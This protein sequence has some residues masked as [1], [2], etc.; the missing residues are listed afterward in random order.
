A[1]GH[2]GQAGAGPVSAAGAMSDRAVRNL[3]IMPAL[4]LLIVFNVFPLLASLAVSFA[5]YNPIIDRKPVFNGLA[6]YAGLLDGPRQEVWRA[7]SRTGAFVAVSV[8]L[9][10]LIGF[11]VALLLRRAFKGRGLFTAILLIP[12]MLSP[13]V[14]GSFWRYLFNA[15]YGAV[16]WLLNARLNWDGSRPLAFW[17][18]VIAE[19]WMWTPFMI[20]LSLAGLN[21]I[22]KAL[23]EAAEVDRAGAWFRFR[24]ITL[25]L[26][27]PM[28]ILGVVF[29]AMEAFRHFDSAM[30]LNGNLEGQPTT[31]VSVLLHARAFGGS[32][33]LG[34]P[35]ALAYLLL[36]ASLA[37]A[38]LVLRYLDH[39]RARRGASGFTG[40]RA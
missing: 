8:G 31:F 24:H 15:D 23:Y 13:A 30:V 25:P 38:S 22:P 9:E 5:D 10:T 27:A 2:P 6:N 34:E 26:A 33:S 21:A 18:V 39:V 20:L 4:G 16:D 40:R 29:R 19:V 32:R 28:V 3:C 17:A 11:G 14:M 36:I 37:L 12:M 1:R 35:A 7:F